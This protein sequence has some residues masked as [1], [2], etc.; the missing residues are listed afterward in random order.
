MR[1][2]FRS[3]GLRNQTLMG[4]GDDMARTKGISL[5][6]AT[7]FCLTLPA[8][9][10]HTLTQR[11]EKVLDTWLSQHPTFRAA[12]DADCDCLDDIQ[13]MKTGYGGNWTPYPDYHPYA[14]TG[15]FN[16]DGAEDFAAVVIDR[17]KTSKNF[18]LLIFNGP[19]GSTQPAPAYVES[20]LDLRGEGMSF[21]P[22]RPKPYRIVVGPFE[23]DNTFILVP[24]GK[25]Y[26]VQVN[27][28]D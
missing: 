8:W 12:T 6:L 13:Q 28:S 25:T 14:V 11:E 15:D 27:D 5:I 7:W 3:V 19:F 21:G 1:L 10:G 16:G 9:C 23:S 4:Q 26:K 2:P 24:K 17:S 22:P 18:T 20:G